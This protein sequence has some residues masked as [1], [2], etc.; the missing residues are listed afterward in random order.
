MAKKKKLFAPKNYSFS[1]IQEFSHRLRVVGSQ[2][3]AKVKWSGLLGHNFCMKS[4]GEDNES[5]EVDKNYYKTLPASL[6]A[7]MEGTN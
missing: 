2:K 7:I 5:G 1:I 6:I 4:K 3:W